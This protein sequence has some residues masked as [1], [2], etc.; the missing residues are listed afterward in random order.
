M[1]LEVRSS[2]GWAPCGALV[3][4]GAPLLCLQARRPHG[5]IGPPLPAPRCGNKWLVVVT[6]ASGTVACM[7]TPDHRVG[8]TRGLEQHGPTHKLWNHSCVNMSDNACLDQAESRGGPPSQGSPMIIHDNSN[9]GGFPSYIVFHDSSYI[10]LNQSV[11]P[12]EGFPR[13]TYIQPPIKEYQ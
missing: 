9:F 11:I 8:S 4:R 5:W 1:W 12:S 6:S 3:A 7:L 10:V 13:A 2:C